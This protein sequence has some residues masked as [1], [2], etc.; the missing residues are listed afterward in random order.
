[1]VGDPLDREPCSPQP[2]Y[3]LAIENTAR[4]PNR[5]PGLRA[6]FPCGLHAAPYTFVDQLSLELSN[7]R[8]DKAYAQ[9]SHDQKE[10]KIDVFLASH[11]VQFDMHKKYQLG[12]A[13][14]PD[15][16]VDPEGF[17]AAVA[18]LEKL[19]RDQLAKEQQRK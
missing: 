9:T 14:N 15:R 5:V 13:Y 8:E 3:F 12:D 1:M 17:Q 4:A 11:A 6:V 7:R 16:F 19:Y 18:R 10:M 2:H